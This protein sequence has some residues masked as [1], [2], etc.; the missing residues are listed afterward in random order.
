MAAGPQLRKTRNLHPTLC[1]PDARSGGHVPAQHSAGIAI[2]PSREKLRLTLVRGG[3][4]SQRQRVRKTGLELRL[5]TTRLARGG[6]HSECPLGSR[7]WCPYPEK[8]TQAE[9]PST[10][11]PSCSEPQTNAEAAPGALAP[12][13]PPDT[14]TDPAQHPPRFCPPGGGH[15]GPGLLAGEMHQTTWPTAR[16]CP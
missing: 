10:S 15:D 16:G 4:R 9:G 11:L 2:P 14:P 3:R 12:G 5:P 6:C 7:L 13:E 8:G 1:R